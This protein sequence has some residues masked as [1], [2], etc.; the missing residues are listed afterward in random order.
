MATWILHGGW[1]RAS[2]AE[3]GGAAHK[4]HPVHAGHARDVPSKR[5]VESVCILPGKVSRGGKCGRPDG[6][7]VA[8]GVRQV[9]QRGRANGTAHIEHPIHAGHARDAPSKRLVER[10]C[11]LPG[12]ARR[13]GKWVATWILRGVWRQASG[14]EA[15]AA[16]H[17]EHPVHAGHARDVPS[18]RLVESGCVLPSVRGEAL[19]GVGD[20]MGLGCVVGGVKQAVQRRCAPGTSRTCWSRSKRPKQA[21]G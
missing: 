7:C 3:A 18:E 6:S 21:A 14:A 17:I 16:A 12:E 11:I 2:G 5:L 13:G 19:W 10:A 1:R 4:E 20:E 15:G 8:G 9:V